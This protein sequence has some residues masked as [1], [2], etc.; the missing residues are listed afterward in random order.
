MLASDS[1]PSTAGSAAVAI[2]SAVAFPKRRA[3]RHRLLSRRR[4]GLSTLRRGRRSRGLGHFQAPE[5]RQQQAQQ[6]QQPKR[7][8]QGRRR[9]SGRHS[10]AAANG[11]ANSAFRKLMSTS[12]SMGEAHWATAA[13]VQQGGQFVD[14]VGSATIEL[15]PA[16]AVGF[17]QMR[18]QGRGE[19]A[20]I[21]RPG[22]SRGDQG[23]AAN[24]AAND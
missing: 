22:C 19:N 1:V 3:S 16:D 4:F 14:Q 21:V 11:S 2:A 12:V 13:G 15:S 7:V 18:P 17:D 10:A 6:R 20:D 23:V 9:N 5:R 8:R 24:L